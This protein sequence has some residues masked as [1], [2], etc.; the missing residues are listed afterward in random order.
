MRMEHV[1][2]AE[3]SLYVVGTLAITSSKSS[4][5]RNLDLILCK[6]WRAK[7][8]GCLEGLPNF[9]IK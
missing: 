7:Y 5:L 2:R 4:V 9:G 3:L 1:G 8:P 6:I